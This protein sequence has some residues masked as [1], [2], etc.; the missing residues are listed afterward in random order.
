MFK[1]SVAYHTNGGE[2]HLHSDP[3]TDGLEHIRFNVYVQLPHEGGRPVYAGVEHKLQ[4]RRYICCWASRDKHKATMVKGDRARVI[5]SYGF[6]IPKS[7][8]GEI[9]YNYPH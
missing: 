6:L 4:E 1:D 3:K 2:L 8:V 7:E 5:I 9:F